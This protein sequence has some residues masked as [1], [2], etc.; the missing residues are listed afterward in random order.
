MSRTTEKR[1]ILGIDPGSVSTGYGIVDAEGN[2]LA[3]VHSGRID[4]RGGA[5]ADR[6]RRI[7]EGISAVVE[8]YEPSEVAVEKVFVARNPD[9]AVKLGQARGAAICGALQAALPVHEYSPSEI[10]QAVVGGG[11]AAKEQVQHMVAM[12]LTIREPLQSDQA[13]AL[14]V[15][16]C[17]AHTAASAVAMARQAVP[18]RRRGWRR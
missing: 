4:A 18:N 13:D 17:H 11:R 16:I 2:R 12:L 9:A 10:K 1:R 15:A 5:F 3:H 6:L 14:A 8:E 7:F